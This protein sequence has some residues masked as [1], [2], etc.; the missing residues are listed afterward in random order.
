LLHGGHP[1]SWDAD[2]GLGI[3]MCVWPPIMTAL[4]GLAGLFL[5]RNIWTQS[6]AVR[7]LKFSRQAQTEAVGASSRGPL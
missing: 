3:F 7:R 6:R 5:L 1:D 4:A 2:A